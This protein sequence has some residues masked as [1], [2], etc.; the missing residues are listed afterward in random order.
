[1]KLI[2]MTSRCNKTVIVVVVVVV[3]LLMVVIYVLFTKTSAA[4]T[5]TTLKSVQNKKLEAMKRILQKLSQPL[6]LNLQT[7][8]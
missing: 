8:L 5:I 6:Y 1:M 7:L 2:I 3:V 4:I